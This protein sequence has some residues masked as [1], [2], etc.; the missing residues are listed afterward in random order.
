MTPPSP[1]IAAAKGAEPLPPERR[2]RVPYLGWRVW[3]RC[4][5]GVCRQLVSS[6]GCGTVLAEDF[7]RDASAAADGDALWAR[8]GSPSGVDLGV[9]GRTP[10]ARAAAAGAAGS[11]CRAGFSHV[12]VEC[13][14]ESGGVL[15]VEV[16]LVVGAVESEQDRLVGAGAIQIV[17][18]CDENLLGY[19]TDGTWR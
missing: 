18:E 3:G 10:A 7:G 16:D 14:A 17:G 8:R 6:S 12:L 19:G 2:L 13:F 4:W 15:G 9:P 11:A 1:I 5:G